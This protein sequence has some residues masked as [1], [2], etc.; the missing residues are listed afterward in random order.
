[1]NNSL[2]ADG[3][4]I[5]GSVEN[6]V[7]FRGVHVGRGAKLKDCIIM[8]DSYIAE[9]VEMENVILDKDVTVRAHGRLMSK[10]EYPIVIGKNVTL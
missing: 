4:V 9:D 10:R 5:E 7:L 6:C 8:Q 2:I 3:C 1:M